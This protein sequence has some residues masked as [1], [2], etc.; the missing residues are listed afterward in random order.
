MLG[1]WKVAD[2]SNEITAVPELLRVL[3]L[4]G[5]IVTMDAMGCQKKIAREIHEADADY[6]LALKGNHQR[7]HDEVRTYLDAVL[8]ERAAPR[9]AG[10]RLSPGAA[11]LA[12]L[13]TVD[14]GTRP[15]GDAPLLS[16]CG[17]E[18]VCRPGPVGGTAVGGDGRGDTGSGRENH[19]G[20]ALLP[21]EP[22]AGSGD[23]CA[24]GAW[25]LGR[26]EPTALGARRVVS[27]RSKRG[28]ARAT[29]RRTLPPCDG[30]R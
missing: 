14:K 7:V 4:S 17:D 9:P 10:A 2:Q 15:A 1:Q 22:A 18:L 6:V 3:E 13:Q 12:A 19:R 29:R 20:T 24:G 25:P 5:C 28:R 30:W 23:V 8:L 11:T 27:G 16:E 26:G 21:V